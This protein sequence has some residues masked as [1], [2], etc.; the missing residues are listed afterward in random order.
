MGHYYPHMM[1]Y[2]GDTALILA[3][4]I[5]DAL[6]AIS[7]FG[8]SAWLFYILRN[9]RFALRLLLLGFASFILV[10]GVGHVGH[11]IAVFYAGK[12]FLWAVAA[13]FLIT[14]IV[15]MGTWML[16]WFSTPA[17]R[18]IMHDFLGYLDTK[19]NQEYVEQGDSKQ[20][21]LKVQKLNEQLD[22]FMATR[23]G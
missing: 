4:I 17:I 1:C 11:I 19:Q 21:L 12:T 3:V 2:G 20:T 15:S 7:Y 23:R 13:E 8:L 22:T 10:C 6:I 18:T 9:K 16:A 14:G 5:G